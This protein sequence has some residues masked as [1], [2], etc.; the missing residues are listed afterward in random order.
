MDFR[1]D[2]GQEP[3]MISPYFTHSLFA[4]SLYEYII[5]SRRDTSQKKE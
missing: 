1:K 4:F 2:I 5:K 3:S